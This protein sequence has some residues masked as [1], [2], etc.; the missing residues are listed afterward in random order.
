MDGKVD[1]RSH[2]NTYRVL[3]GYPLNPL[4]RT[5]VCLRGL[6]GRWGQSL[7]QIIFD[8]LNCVLRA[9]PRGRPH[10]HAVCHPFS[11]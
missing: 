2:R 8:R 7:T 6:L 4:G 3:N 1:R 9:E 5:G 10:C 11:H